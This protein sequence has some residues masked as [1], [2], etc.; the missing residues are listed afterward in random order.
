MREWPKALNHAGRKLQGRIR[1]MRDH[2]ASLQRESERF[3]VE[4]RAYEEVATQLALFDQPPIRR[5][6]ARAA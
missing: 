1:S 2:L 4:E 5:R 3:A 6:S